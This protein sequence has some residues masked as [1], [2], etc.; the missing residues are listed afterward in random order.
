MDIYK[1]LGCLWVLHCIW[2]PGKTI[3]I[4]EILRLCIIYSSENYRFSWNKLRFSGFLI[5]S[6]IQHFKF[7]QKWKE[8]KLHFAT[9][10]P[11]RS[12]TDILT[13]VIWL[14]PELI[15]LMSVSELDLSLTLTSKC[16]SSQTSP[17]QA[18]LCFLS[19]LLMHSCF[20]M[21]SFLQINS[22]QS[23]LRTRENLNWWVARKYLRTYNNLKGVTRYPWNGCHPHVNPH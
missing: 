5:T 11:C 19:R 3:Y 13:T 7:P 8:R 15:G 17:C 9:P 23:E 21:H 4:V 12:T 2:W 22:S 6:E 20:L 10:L 18:K 16:I 1:T 14:Q